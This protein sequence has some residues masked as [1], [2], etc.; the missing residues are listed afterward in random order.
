VDARRLPTS[1]RLA[2]LET[3]VNAL[4]TGA[5]IS[6][7]G[8]RGGRT[9][10]MNF[11]QTKGREADA[12]VLVFRDGDY[13]ANHTDTEPFTDSSRVLYVALTRARRAVTV[14]LPPEPHP[15]IA[16]FSALA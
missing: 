7:A 8:P 6:E 10:L 5:L 3:E 4:R 14:I 9:T 16:P 1:D 15:L 13:L 12:V 2:L 11:H